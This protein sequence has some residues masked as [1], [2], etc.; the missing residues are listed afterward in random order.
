DRVRRPE[1]APAV[2]R[3][4]IAEALTP[5]PGSVSV[6]VPIDFQAQLITVPPIVASTSPAQAPADAELASAVE[7]IVAAKR[8]VIWAGSGAM[9]SDSSPEV[10]ALME[11]IDAAVVTTQYGRGIVAETDSRCI[12]TFTTYPTLLGYMETAVLLLSS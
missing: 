7:R 9:F 12:G 5:P 8:P 10:S 1:Q 6:E 11:L 3:R 2:F 4:A